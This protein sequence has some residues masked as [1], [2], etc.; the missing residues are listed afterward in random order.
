MASSAWSGNTSGLASATSPGL[1]GTSTQTFAG[2]KTLDGGALIAGDTSGSIISSPYVGQF[3]GTQSTGTNGSAYYVN[4][5]T[6]VTATNASI[7]STTVNKGIY[8]CSYAV[9]CYQTDGVNRAF[10]TA[11]RIGGTA[12]TPTLVVD[13]VNNTF[14]SLSW[15]VPII[16][17]ADSTTVA[18][19]AQ[20]QLLTGSTSGNQSMISLL[21]VG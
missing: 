10:N 16:I 13:T 2:K 8:F 9:R 4:S 19:Y 6:A 11:L 20:M 14:F 17:T 5:T 3:L 15:S 21:R 18:L 7:C 1:V 12:V